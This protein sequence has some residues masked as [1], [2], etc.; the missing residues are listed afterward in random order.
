MTDVEFGEGL[1]MGQVYS[2]AAALYDALLSH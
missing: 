2:M 1:A